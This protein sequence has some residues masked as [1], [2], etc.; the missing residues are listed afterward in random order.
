[1]NNNQMKLVPLS[2]KFIYEVIQNV[3]ELPD[4]NSPDD[5]PEAMLV[6]GEELRQIM[7]AVNEDVPAIESL[8][9]VSD[10][11]SEAVAWL[12]PNRI[13]MSKARKVHFTRTPEGKDK[14]DDELKEQMDGL[15]TYCA[16]LFSDHSASDYVEDKHGNKHYYKP[17]YERPQPDLTASLQAE[18]KRLLE[19]LKET[20]EEIRSGIESNVEL[21][22]E[23]SVSHVN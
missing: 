1:M 5:W 2:D 22:A 16:E 13:D 11:N 23:H 10:G 20:N 12:I 19:A 21:E 4:R 14:T 9:P 8:P 6:T 15:V 18:N 3:A 17:L 7:M